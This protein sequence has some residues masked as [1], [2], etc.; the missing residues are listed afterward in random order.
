MFVRLPLDGGLEFS[1]GVT[2]SEMAL[3][4]VLLFHRT[5]GVA[6]YSSMLIRIG[7]QNVEI[8]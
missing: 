2:C 8:E 5:V 6:D 4:S 3:R 1:S 7:K